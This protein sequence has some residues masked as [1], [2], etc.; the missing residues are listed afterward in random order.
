MET[1]QW[2]QKRIKE[3]ESDRSKITYRTDPERF[4]G[5]GGQLCALKNVLNYI[6]M[7]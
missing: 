7:H 5:K 3:I 4:V 6:N 2:L 1:K